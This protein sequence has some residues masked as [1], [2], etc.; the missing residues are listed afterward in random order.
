MVIQEP[1]WLNFGNLSENH[2][3]DSLAYP[4]CSPPEKRNFHR[5]EI[6]GVPGWWTLPFSQCGTRKFLSKSQATSWNHVVKSTKQ[7]VMMI[8]SLNTICVSGRMFTHDVTKTNDNKAAHCN[9][10][11]IALVHAG[12]TFRHSST[13]VPVYCCSPPDG[14][15]KLVRVVLR[16]S[17]SLMNNLNR[18]ASLSERSLFH[19]MSLTGKTAGHCRPLPIV[20]LELAQ[21]GL[22]IRHVQQRCLACN[23]SVAC[24]GGFCTKSRKANLQAVA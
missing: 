11:R 13:A 23:P 4:I 22:Q 8:H 1:S 3:E 17:N 5:V 16:L 14:P 9:E 18:Y 6:G 10:W 2:L 20:K 12:L 7:L 19:A 21:A 24:T 15:A